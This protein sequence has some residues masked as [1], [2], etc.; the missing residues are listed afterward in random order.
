MSTLSWM[1]RLHGHKRNGVWRELPCP[2]RLDLSW[3][4]PL[5]QVQAPIGQLTEVFRNLLD[6][7]YR[8][9]RKKGEAH[10]S[11]LPN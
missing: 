1:K 2:S 9:M 6:N 10:C 3:L 8:A 5:P 4:D 7:A 11:Q